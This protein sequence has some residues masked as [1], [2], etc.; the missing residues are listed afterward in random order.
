[1]FIRT[2]AR[3]NKDGSRIKYLQPVHKWTKASSL[4]KRVYKAFELKLPGELEIS[5]AE[6]GEF[7]VL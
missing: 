3:K 2:T 7:G 6:E 4:V 5:P 1:M